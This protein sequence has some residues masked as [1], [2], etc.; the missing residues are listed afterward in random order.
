MK[1]QTVKKTND[2]ALE[3]L[4]DGAPDIATAVID[5]KI[6]PY[7]RALTT[8]HSSGFRNFE[9]G[10]CSLDGTKQTVLTHYSDHIYWAEPLMS[11]IKGFPM[12]ATFNMD[13]DRQGHLRIYRDFMWEHIGGSCFLKYIG[14]GKNQ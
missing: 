2:V 5:G 7:V 9:A 4:L 6:V 8:V 12:I 1:K 13:C 14:N 3:E 11:G 10:Y